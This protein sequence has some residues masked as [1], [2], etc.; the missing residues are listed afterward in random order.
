MDWGAL[1]TGGMSLAGSLFG[2]NSA[3]QTNVDNSAQAQRS[4]D[5]QAAQAQLNRDFSAQQAKNEMDFQ[6]RMSNTS[7]QRR[8]ADLSAAGWNPIL[9]A[10]EGASTPQGAMGQ[11]FQPSG[12]QATMENP[13]ED[14][15]AD[16]ATSAK[17]YADLAMN[18]E[19]IKTQQS[20]QLL[21]AASAKNALANASWAESKAKIG[22][23]GTRGLDAI[24]NITGKIASMFGRNTAS[25]SFAGRRKG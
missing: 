12:A 6:E 2:A 25:L 3:K 7:V 15:G 1:L 24:E 5:F 23:W 8:S 14:L 16:V 9:A 22:K 10:M 17:T 21:N 19:M 13:Y 18:K 20:Q 4:M 11:G